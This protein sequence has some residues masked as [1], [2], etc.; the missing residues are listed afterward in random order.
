MLAVMSDDDTVSD[1]YRDGLGGRGAFRSCRCTL[2]VWH[3][4]F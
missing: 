4:L 2:S 1:V 3:C